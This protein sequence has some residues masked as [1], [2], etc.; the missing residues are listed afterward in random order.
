MKN[1]VKPADGKS[2]QGRKV[3]ISKKSVQ[4]YRVTVQYIH[5]SGEEGKIKRAI[6]ES[7]MRKGYNK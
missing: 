4:R 7:I 6:I 3:I 1:Q 2:V 5:I